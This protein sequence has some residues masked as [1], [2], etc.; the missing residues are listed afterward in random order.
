MSKCTSCNTE[1]ELCH[2]LEGEEGF[3]SDYLCVNDECPTA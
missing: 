2:F 3:V 1:L